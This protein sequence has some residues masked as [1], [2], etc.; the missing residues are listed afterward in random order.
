MSRFVTKSVI[1]VLLLA[2]AIFAAPGRP[3]YASA[4][5]FNVTHIHFDL[6]TAMHVE[7]NFTWY[8]RSVGLSNIWLYVAVNECGWVSFY[9]YQNNTLIDAES[10]AHYCAIGTGQWI[11]I[12]NTV[13]DASQ[14]RGGIN[15]VNVAVHDDTDGGVN[16]GVYYR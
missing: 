10:T 1:V 11:N 14:V 7:G 2:G 16:Y 6:S 15:K 13:L 3:A 9:G 4:P 12:P 5:S 8:N